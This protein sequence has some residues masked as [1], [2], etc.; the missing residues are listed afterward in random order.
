[1]LENPRPATADPAPSSTDLFRSKL[2][3]L[4]A[5][6]RSVPPL[7]LGEPG[8][9]QEEVQKLLTV[10]TRVPDHGMLEPWRIILVQGASR[11]KLGARL[12]ATFLKLNGEQD[13]AS[14]ELAI[15]KIKTVLSAPL[16]IIVVS[17]A[18]PAARI[19]EWEQILSA[20]ALCMNLI[21]AATALGYGATWLTGWAAYN[22][23]A[24]QVIG[25][26]AFEKVAGV[27]PIGTAIESQ[28]ERARPSLQKLLTQWTGT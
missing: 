12:A 1:M 16:V 18:D 19:P 11:E 26:Q 6:R 4:L 8:P 22:P 27:I 7:Q 9:S 20:G 15:R 23:A 14:S 3:D 17:R 28:Q 2:L 13:P 24:L 21:T 25:V 5:R 10:A